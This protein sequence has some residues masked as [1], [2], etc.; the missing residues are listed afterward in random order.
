[1]GI[2]NCYLLSLPKITDT[3]GNLTFIESEKH[4]PFAIKRTFYIYGVPLG[5]NRAGHAHRNLQEFIIAIS[6]SFDLIINDGYESRHFHLNHPF[7]GIYI[8]PM[9]WGDLKNFSSDAV[10]LVLVSDYYDELN[11]IRDYKQYLLEQGVK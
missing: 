8:T 5:E 2:E 3:R 1:M 9:I 6:G 4:I 11:Y 7:Q 10:C